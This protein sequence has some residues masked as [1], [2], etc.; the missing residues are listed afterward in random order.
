MR[1]A[2]VAACAVLTAASGSS[3]AAAIVRCESPDGRVTY[4]NTECPPNTRAVRQVDLSPPVIV[5]DAATAPARR[6]EP[7]P[8][9]LEPARSRRDEDPLQLDEELTAQLAAQRRE[10]EGRLR[11]LQRLQQDLDVAPPPAR[12]SAELALRRAQED[13]RALCPRA[14]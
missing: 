14:R 2:P 12:A 5:H 7:P 13:Y 4:A 6:G 9:R 3:E 11:E 1:F 10:C 8:P